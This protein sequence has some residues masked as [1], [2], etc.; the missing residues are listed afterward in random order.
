MAADLAQDAAVS[1]EGLEVA[2]AETAARLAACEQEQQQARL[3][4]RLTEALR[5]LRE[6]EASRPGHDQRAARLAAAR[7]AEPVRPLLAALAARHSRRS[8][9]P[10]AG[11]LRLVPDPDDTMLAGGGAA[12]AFVRAEAAEKDAAS[13][14][15]LADAEA[16]LPGR[17]TALR[18]AQQAVAGAA[19]LVRRLEAARADLPGQIAAVEEQLAAAR[20]LAAG[21]GAAREQQA[22][23]GRAAP[24]P[25]PTWPAWS[26]CSR[27]RTRPCS[28]P[29]T[30]H[31]ALTDA[32]LQA[33]GGP[34][35]RHG[36]GAGRA[37]R[38]RGRV[39]G[40]RLH[41]PPGPGPGGRRSGV[42]AGPRR[43]RGPA[44]RGGSR[45]APS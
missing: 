15:H 30:R 9:R 1:A 40:L 45:R 29:W 42:R 6:H 16:G 34:A 28:T 18:A 36:R 21:L 20:L 39:P 38:R 32:H 31:Q 17:V 33:D 8:A 10:A 19:G 23:A 2:A 44:G 35:G 27:T 25:P 41:R 11:L 26:R 13:L 3:M 43:G 12:Q 37:A 7:R 5:R 22:G 4:T 24:P 14:Q